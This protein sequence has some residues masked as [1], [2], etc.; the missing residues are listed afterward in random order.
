MR[1]VRRQA[2]CTSQ[3]VTRAEMHLCSGRRPR[4]GCRARRVFWQK[5]ELGA[6]ERTG[7][8]GVPRGEGGRWG[9]RSRGVRDMGVCSGS[10]ARDRPHRCAAD[11][12]RDSA[13]PFS[14]TASAQTSDLT[15]PDPNSID[16]LL[17]F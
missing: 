16:R 4:P 11:I 9:C 1:L 7:V 14:L 15:C 13:S 3:L 5:G 2:V 10:G 6:W 8:G 17:S 12:G